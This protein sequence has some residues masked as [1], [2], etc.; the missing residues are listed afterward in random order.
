MKVNGVICY[1]PLICRQDK[2]CATCRLYQAGKLPPEHPMPVIPLKVVLYGDSFMYDTV[3]I[4]TVYPDDSVIV[5]LWDFNFDRNL[6][7]G[8]PYGEYQWFETPHLRSA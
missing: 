8:T 4:E 3:Y 1:F 5:C 6:D 2:T 7:F